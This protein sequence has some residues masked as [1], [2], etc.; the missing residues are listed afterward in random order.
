MV[1]LG[2][3]E[4]EERTE[5]PDNRDSLGL[6][7]HLVRLDRLGHVEKQVLQVRPE[8]QALRDS[9]EARDNV[10]KQ[11]RPDNQ[12]LLVRRAVWE[13]LDFLVLWVNLVLQAALVNQDNQAHKDN[14]VQ[15]ELLV[16][17]GLRGPRV[18]QARVVNRISWSAG[19]GW[20]ERGCRGD[21]CGWSS[22]I[23]WTTRIPRSG[24]HPWLTW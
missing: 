12:G 6:R 7:D 21:R 2:P 24:R 5:R 11:D 9:Q 18:H 4:A 19:I 15:L 1:S 16:R 22:R 8:M 13:L 17:L 23:K 14:P 20:S 3:L 10:V